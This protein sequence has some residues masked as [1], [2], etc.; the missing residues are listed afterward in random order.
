MISKIDILGYLNNRTLYGV[1][2]VDANDFLHY[3]VCECEVRNGKIV[4]YSSFNGIS[5]DEL[6]R[7]I[8]KRGKVILSYSSEKVFLSRRK[9]NGNEG[10]RPN[11]YNSVVL[12][13]SIRI[14]DEEFI[15][16][17]KHEQY[18]NVLS[19]LEGLNIEA[20][21]LGGMPVL[22]NFKLFVEKDIMTSFYHILE[23]NKSITI[24]SLASNDAKP[25]NKYQVAGFRLS[26]NSVMPFM[27]VYEF[28]NEDDSGFDISPENA[29]RSKKGLKISK[30][31]LIPALM[32]VFAI[33]LGNMLLFQK[34]NRANNQI[35]AQMIDSSLVH[36]EYNR[37]KLI[38]QNVSENHLLT[39]YDE[40]I[41]LL[42]SMFVVMPDYII[43]REVNMI[44][45]NLKSNDFE[46][47]GCI[48]QMKGITDKLA[49]INHWRNQLNEMHDISLVEQGVLQ[50]TKEGLYFELLVT[51]KDE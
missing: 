40:K 50:D 6:K 12:R 47:G 32:I 49:S 45:I 3:N 46:V 14:D 29:Y 36:K 8:N 16:L 13:Q 18:S 11:D 27:A 44:P 10:G 23:R 51:L 33:L 42:D 34:Y 1:E 37:L 2:I 38:N 24:K 22:K 7:I 41:K 4:N 19:E 35:R 17:I 30:N 28:I 25:I 39:T 26:S 9:L 48:F 20:I 15:F 43:L 5:L 31:T 21:Y